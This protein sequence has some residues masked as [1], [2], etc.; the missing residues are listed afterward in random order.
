MVSGRLMIN[1]PLL[2]TLLCAPLLGSCAA[3]IGHSSIV[4]YGVR[5]YEVIRDTLNEV[6]VYGSPSSGLWID[7]NDRKHTIIHDA[8]MN[9]LRSDI[10]MQ[11]NDIDYYVWYYDMRKNS[12]LSYGHLDLKSEVMNVLETCDTRIN[13]AMA[14]INSGAGLD[15]G[16]IIL[17]YQHPELGS[18]RYVSTLSVKDGSVDVLEISGILPMFDGGKIVYLST[19]PENWMWIMEYDKVSGA[20]RRLYRADSERRQ[21][22]FPALGGVFITHDVG[23]EELLSYMG[24]DNVTSSIEI[25]TYVAESSFICGGYPAFSA[26]EVVGDSAVANVYILMNNEI[27]KLNL[28]DLVRMTPKRGEGLLNECSVEIS[29]YGIPGHGT[30][31]LPV[32]RSVRIVIDSLTNSIEVRPIS[33]SR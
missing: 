31:I 14:G 25:N 1:T 20:A 5:S 9:V 27:R 7:A 23:D 16:K 4:S 13:W 22:I 6:K 17:S 30:E 10:S 15:D 28:G 33:E 8:Y 11:G 24:P 21:G 29:E 3:Q 19:D 26:T 2:I 32:P 18:N 12:C